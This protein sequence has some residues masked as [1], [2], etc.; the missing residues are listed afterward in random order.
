MRRGMTGV[1][2]PALDTMRK[3]RASYP[4]GLRIAP[5]RR[6][7]R[8]AARR[9]LAVAAHQPELP[10]RSSSSKARRARGRGRARPG[11]R[12]R[13]GSARGR[14]TAGRRASRLERE[15]SRR[16][17]RRVPIAVVT[18]RRQAAFRS[19]ASLRFLSIPFA[20][21]VRKRPGYHPLPIGRWRLRS[22]RWRR[23][24]GGCPARSGLC[25]VLTRSPH[26]DPV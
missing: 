3:R 11:R 20:F 1:A 9:M 4:M 7:A 25:R 23:G 13:S 8:V 26:S 18:P 22:R 10:D 21:G 14:G 19:G 12:R 15:N 6:G 5:S 24:T 17:G 2:P 16:R